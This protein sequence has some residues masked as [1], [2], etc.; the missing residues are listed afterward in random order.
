MN[1]R[2]IC[3]T[4]I[5]LNTNSLSSHHKLSLILKH[6][7]KFNPH[8]IC[9]Q[10]TFT[11]KQS[12]PTKFEISLLKSKWSGHSY[13]TKHLAILIHPQFSSK[14]L[15]IS[16][17][18]RIM[19]IQITS[20]SSISYIIRNTYAP[21][22]HNSSFWQTFPPSLLSPLISY[23]LVTLTLQHNYVTAGLL[24]LILSTLQTYL[25]FLSNSL[26]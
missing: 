24:S 9:L 12:M 6:L 17:D 1:N 16:N 23:A 11:S 13:F 2:T 19:D 18:E 20:P 5:S 14:I 25:F 7:S 22:F 10:E 21:P 8:I 3:P 4:I 26:T 15:Y